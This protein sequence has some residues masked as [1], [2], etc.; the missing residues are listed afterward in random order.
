MDVLLSSIYRA[1]DIAP[2]QDREEAPFS[3]ISRRRKSIRCDG[4]PGV[5]HEATVMVEALKQILD[6]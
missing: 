2:D 6:D 5:A 3:G 1:G 4:V